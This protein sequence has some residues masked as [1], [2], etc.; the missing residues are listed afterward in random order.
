MLSTNFVEDVFCQWPMFCPP[1]Y[2][3]ESTFFYIVKP[4]QISHISKRYIE[5]SVH[6]LNGEHSIHLRPVGSHILFSKAYDVFLR[7]PYKND[8]PLFMRS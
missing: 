2:S 3:V 7:F 8:I 1:R 5:F 6:V 4:R